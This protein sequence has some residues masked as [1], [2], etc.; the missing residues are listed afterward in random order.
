LFA[1]ERGRARVCTVIMPQLNYLCACVR[2]ADELP[3]RLIGCCRVKCMD[4]TVA[5][6]MTF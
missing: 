1:C 6:K 3:E 2:A 5:K 4:L